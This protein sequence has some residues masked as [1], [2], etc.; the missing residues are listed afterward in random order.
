M[1]RSALRSARTRAPS[2][3]ERLSGIGRVPPV[4]ANQNVAGLLLGCAPSN[5]ALV[6]LFAG[7]I[8]LRRNVV[9]PEAATG[10]EPF[11]GGFERWRSLARPNHFFS[12]IFAKDVNVL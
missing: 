3:C 9:M 10:N 11:Q 12:I 1:P 6:P 2:T 7:T 5:A 8:S 4:I